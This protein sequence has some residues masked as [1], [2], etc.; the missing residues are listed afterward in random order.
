M[1]IKGIFD[2][3]GNERVGK[4]MKIRSSIATSAN[5]AGIVFVLHVDRYFSAMYHFL[6]S[7]IVVFLS[8][9]FRIHFGRALC[10]FQLSR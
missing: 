1:Q 9:L 8:Q 7:G 10:A 4:R 3:I 6:F 5:V 2:E